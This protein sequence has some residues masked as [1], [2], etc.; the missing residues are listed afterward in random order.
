M[1]P[2]FLDKQEQK[3]T[4]VEPLCLTKDLQSL[5]SWLKIKA[6]ET[7]RQVR[8][9]WIEVIWAVAAL[10]QKHLQEQAHKPEQYFFETH[11]VARQVAYQ[12]NKRHVN[13]RYVTD[14]LKRIS[15]RQLEFINQI[16]AADDKVAVIG[17]YS[18][19]SQRGLG[20]A[21]MTKEAAQALCSDASGQGNQAEI[22]E[23]DNAE[24]LQRYRKFRLI[25]TAAVTVMVMVMVIAMGVLMYQRTTMVDNSAINTLASIQAEGIM[26]CGVDGLLPHFSLL[27]D[28][29]QTWWGLDVELCKALGAALN[30]K[31]GIVKVSASQFERRIAPLED[32]TVHVLFRNTS[33][34]ITR[35]LKANI[36]FGPVYFY[37]QEV[38][39]DLS[40]EK[41]ATTVNLEDIRDK[42]VCVKPGTS[43]ERTLQ[44]LKHEINFQAITH[45]DNNDPLIDNVKMLRT[46]RENDDHCDFVFGNY[47]VLKQL[48]TDQER[49]HPE[50][51]LTLRTFARAGLDPLAP[52]LQKDYQWQQV[53]NYSIYA[54]FYAEKLGINSYNV[55]EKYHSG[56]PLEQH[57]LRGENMEMAGL[58]RNWVYRIIS[59][60]GN[61]SEIYYRSIVCDYV[62]CGKPS[63]DA[64]YTEM[65]NIDDTRG[66]NKVF[67]KEDLK[68]GLL[69]TPRF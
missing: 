39:L 50:K 42:N 46:L 4:G 55:E 38:F 48:K 12:Q 33:H 62:D 36:I 29:E 53:I 9:A 49:R 25:N 20:L 18:T 1:I 24:V 13:T 54:L 44:N 60:V 66:A 8:P 3:K 15:A 21:L 56:S 19:S 10:A 51:S 59:T 16:G 5:E 63:E 35:D 31:L 30:V 7:N 26:R 22:V 45:D 52:V 67:N 23:R 68:P 69:Y 14:E 37:E 40:A 43:N 65:K 47:F 27:N 41:T 57:F 64:F 11:V 17:W 61:Y 32:Q 58:T 34:T 28:A 6:S 2:E